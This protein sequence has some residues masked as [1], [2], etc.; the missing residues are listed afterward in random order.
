MTRPRRA[1]GKLSKFFGLLLVFGVWMP[2]WFFAEYSTDTMNS[3]DG[4][5]AEP[6]RGEVM[7]SLKVNG[8]LYI[9]THFSQVHIRYFHCCWPILVQKSPLIRQLHIIVA[10][11][12]STDIPREE[13]DYL[14]KTL[15]VNNPSYRFLTPVNATHMTHCQ[16]LQDD[17]GKFAHMPF[18]FKQCLANYG[19]YFGWSLLEQFDWMIRLNPD[20]LIRESKW[21][22]Q[23]MQNTSLDA[24]LISCGEKRQQLHTDFW[25]VR[26]SAVIPANGDKVPFESLAKRGSRVNHEYT[27]YRNFRSIVK[28][29]RSAWVPGTDPS[30]GLCRVRG[31]QSLVL[32]DHG[33]CDEDKESS[34]TGLQGWDLT[35]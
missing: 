7:D 28:A 18:V 14:E 19:A 3:S 30:N 4:N 20:V 6:R 2:L 24:L 34:C 5:M 11:T 26:P 1:G 15:F 35:I 27:A 33:G 31:D 10:A 12:N 23:S 16:T 32:H 21:F 29:N 8:V 17:A 9:T 13:L 22:L 25:A